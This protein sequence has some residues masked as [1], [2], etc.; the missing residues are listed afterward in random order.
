MTNPILLHITFKELVA[1]CRTRVCDICKTV[2]LQV[3]VDHDHKTGFV[4]G[5]LC[6]SHNSRLRYDSTHFTIPEMI[7]L[8]QQQYDMQYDLFKLIQGSFSLWDIDET[9]AYWDSAFREY[10]SQSIS[11][12]AFARRTTAKFVALP[13]GVR[14]QNYAEKIP[15]GFC[16]IVD[17]KTGAFVRLTKLNG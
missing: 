11:K 12:K 1:R 15:R 16:A 9:V 5:I 3:F 2:Q 8:N 10:A 4:R 7:Y 14:P 6:P 17:T 13:P